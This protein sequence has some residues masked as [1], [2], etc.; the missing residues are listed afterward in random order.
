MN[1]IMEPAP[2]RTYPYPCT[3]CRGRFFCHCAILESAGYCTTCKVYHCASH[4]DWNVEYFCKKCKGLTKC[5]CYLTEDEPCTKCLQV[6][7]ICHLPLMPLHFRICKECRLF[8]CT[9]EKP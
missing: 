8:E 5:Y 4:G 7:C 3:Q 1:L 9:C 2:P 6:T